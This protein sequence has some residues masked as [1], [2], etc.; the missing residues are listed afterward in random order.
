MLLNHYTDSKSVS[1]CVCV[2]VSIHMYSNFFIFLLLIFTAAC[3]PSFP[4]S[5][6]PRGTKSTFVST[7]PTA[8]CY[9]NFNDLLSFKVFDMLH[10]LGP[11]LHSDPLLLCKIVRIG[12]ACFKDLFTQCS[13]SDGN[14]GLKYE[15]LEKVRT[16]VQ[17]IC[18][19]IY[20]C[21]VHNYTYI[22]TCILLF[23]L[24]FDRFCPFWM[25]LFYHLYQ[26]YNVTV[27]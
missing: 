11:K 8:Q 6:S 16:S 25:K 1:V 14:G 4:Y 19:H 24:C 23:S 10:V 18:T 13:P 7:L 22:N 5:I 21:M 26:C 20:V 9:H 3:F 17:L 27:V 2:C 15:V 12:K